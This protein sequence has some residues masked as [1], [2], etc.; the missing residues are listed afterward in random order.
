MKN[1]GGGICKD[2]EG[3]GKR[4]TADSTG[5]TCLTGCKVQMQRGGS[6]NLDASAWEPGGWGVFLP[7]PQGPQEASQTG[8][9]MFPPEEGLP[10]MP[11][12]RVHGRGRR[13][14]SSA[15]RLWRQYQ[16]GEPEMTP[17]ASQESREVRDARGTPRLQDSGLVSCSPQRPVPP[18]QGLTCQR[19]RMT[20]LKPLRSG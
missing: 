19:S 2:P 4:C 14:K 16:Q 13:A 8:R 5:Y 10:V 7:R 1:S 20:P 3:Q 9:E 17:E 12:Q 6:K 15:R 11:P 18:P